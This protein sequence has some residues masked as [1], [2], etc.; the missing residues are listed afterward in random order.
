MSHCGIFAALDRLEEIL[1]SRAEVLALHL[2]RLVGGEAGHAAARV[3]V[4][5]HQHRVAL[6]VH[7]LVGVDAEALHVPVA[8][9][10]AARAEQ[11]RQHVHRLGRLAHEVEDPVRLLAEGDR[12]RLQRVDDVRELD[13]IADEEHREVVA[14]EIPVAVLGIELHR[15][16]ARVAG[17]P[18]RSRGRR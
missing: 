9:R 8:R 18:R 14:D 15:E 11:M 6:G 10:D 3:E 16:A 17:R 1:G 4:V 7:H 5:L 12:I 2:R 13:R